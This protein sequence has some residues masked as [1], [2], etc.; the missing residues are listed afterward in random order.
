M[1]QLA[2]AMISELNDAIYALGQQQKSSLS[3]QSLHRYY[4]RLDQTQHSNDV[5][6]HGQTR[7]R[8][9]SDINEKSLRDDHEK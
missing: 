9:L 5:R 2:D 3:A 1:T 6:T 8:R 7:P 4:T